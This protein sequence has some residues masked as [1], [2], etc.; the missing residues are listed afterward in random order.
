MNREELSFKYS[1]LGSY[2]ED[3]YISPKATIKR[4]HLA[5]I[6]SHVAID[7]CVITTRLKVGNYVHISPYTSVIGGEEGL[8]EMGNFTTISAGCRIVCASDEFL[9]KGLVSTTIPPQFRDRVICKPVVMQDY[10]SLGSNVVVMP[11]VTIG[12]GAVV[13]ANSFVKKDIPDWTI[14]AGFPA[15]FIKFRSDYKMKAYGEQ[16]L[17]D[18]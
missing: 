12:E 7:E 13:G 18:E 3:V 8:L 2:G 5:H 1:D 11:G 6:G 10:A 16:L 17:R 9:G 15:K 4:P 14:Y